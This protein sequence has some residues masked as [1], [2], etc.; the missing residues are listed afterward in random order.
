MSKPQAPAPPDYAAAATAQ[1][2]ANENSALAT[3]YLNQVNQVGPYGSL[4]YNYNK[5]VV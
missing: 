2:Q 3:N 4:T 1:G 5:T